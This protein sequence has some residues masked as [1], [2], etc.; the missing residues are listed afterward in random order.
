M[1]NELTKEEMIEVEAGGIGKILKD[2]W[3]G[4]WDGFSEEMNS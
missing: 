4:F 2:I 3:N 1:F